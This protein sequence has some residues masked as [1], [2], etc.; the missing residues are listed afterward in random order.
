[1]MGMSNPSDRKRLHNLR[2]CAAAASCVLTVMRTNSEP[3]LASDATCATVAA[4]SA[5]SVFVIDWTTMGWSAPTG[6]FPTW[7]V[8][9]DRL[10]MIAMESP[11]TS[12]RVRAYE[13]VLSSVK[14]GPRRQTA[15]GPDTSPPLRTDLATASLGACLSPCTD[16]RSRHRGSS[17]QCVLAE[18]ERDADLHLD[19]HRDSVPFAR[20]EPP[21]QQCFTRT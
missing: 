5:V 13:I 9:V 18:I 4:M 7:E 16:C 2:H 21:V 3:A 1:M 20:L 12:N 14:P 11:R 8:T 6:T 15:S 19:V 10:W 17:S